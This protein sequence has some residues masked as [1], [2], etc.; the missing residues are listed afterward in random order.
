MNTPAYVNAHTHLELGMLAE[1]CPDGQPFAEWLLGMLPLRA[2][3]T[4]ADY[5]RAI[6]AGIAALVEEISP[7][8]TVPASTRAAMP[9]SM[10][11]W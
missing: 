8:A 4:P 6:E 9:A 7:T 10:A 3:I 5:Q 2:R 11:R 1:L